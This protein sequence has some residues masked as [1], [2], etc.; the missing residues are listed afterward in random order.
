MS[1]DLGHYSYRGARAMILLHERHLRTFVA[2][3]REAKAANVRLPETTDSDYASLETLLRHNLAAA[4]GYMTWMCEKL[5]LPDPKI[6]DAP[7]VED[8]EHGV[9]AYLEH[10]FERW[11]L[12]LAGVPEDDF[13]VTY[14]SRWGVDYCIDGMLE[15]A[16]MHPIRHEFQL[17]NLI[18]EQLHDKTL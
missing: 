10:L 6:A 18:A 17:R 9:E 13:G 4:R 7:M 8:I 14:R 15:H 1:E 16:V 11:R 2:T 5:E 12:P 3:W